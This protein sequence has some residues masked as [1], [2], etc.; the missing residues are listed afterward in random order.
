MMATANA[1]A[2]EKAARL[3]HLAK[4]RRAT[5]LSF[6]SCEIS[7]RRQRRAR[8]R[9]KETLLCWTLERIFFSLIRLLRFA[10]GRENFQRKID[11]W[12]KNLSLG[13]IF[14][15]FATRLCR[16]GRCISI[17]CGRF[18]YGESS[19]LFYLSVRMKETL[20]KHLKKA[21]IFIWIVADS[22]YLNCVLIWFIYS[23]IS[24]SENLIN[25]RRDITQNHRWILQILKWAPYSLR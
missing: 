25:N 24:S 4:K 16:L 23:I 5:D 7:R 22:L 13:L 18:V 21:V 12:C 11:S 14:R 9:K 8:E 20:V 2:E 6:D 1:R 19:A 10:S 3:V 17:S 15:T